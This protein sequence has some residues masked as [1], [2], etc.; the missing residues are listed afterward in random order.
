MDERLNDKS[1][2]AA[3]SWDHSELAAVARLNDERELRSRHP[4]IVVGRKSRY[5]NDHV[6]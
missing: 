3:A 1:I 4:S 6:C 2:L 5:V